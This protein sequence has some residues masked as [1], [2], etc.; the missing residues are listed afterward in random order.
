[1]IATILND[2]ERCKA[3]FGTTAH[4][5]GQMATILSNEPDVVADSKSAHIVNTV[6][7]TL[8]VVLDSKPLPSFWS[9]YVEN[10]KTMYQLVDE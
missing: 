4:L 6:S 8:G 5:K 1:V 3:L 2:K 10:S 9:T 7:S